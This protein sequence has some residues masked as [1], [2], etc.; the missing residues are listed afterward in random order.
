MLRSL[1][2][3]KL[4]FVKKFSIFFKRDGSRVKPESESEYDLPL[5]W[6][7]NIKR[8]SE[9]VSEKRV[10]D[11]KAAMKRYIPIKTNADGNFYHSIGVSDLYR[12][13]ENNSVNRDLCLD[14]VLYYT[15]N[16]FLRI[17]LKLR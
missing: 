17:L 2:E 10:A 4:P 15:V 3:L 12:L 11:L 9:G 13:L 1:K 14:L 16:H 7:S 5:E 8:F 6:V